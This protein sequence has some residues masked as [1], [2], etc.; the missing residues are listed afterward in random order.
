MQLPQ[1]I[2]TIY[3]LSELRSIINNTIDKSLIMQTAMKAVEIVEH[4]ET[5]KQGKEK[6]LNLLKNEI[7][8]YTNS[9]SEIEIVQFQLASTILMLCLQFIEGTVDDMQAMMMAFTLRAA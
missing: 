2:E 9:N 1:H 4:L 8:T 3:R 7:R 5:N 6:I